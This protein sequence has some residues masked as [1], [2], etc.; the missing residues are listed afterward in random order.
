MPDH[1][2]V[3]FTIITI[4]LNSAGTIERTI[5]SVL[6]QKYDNYEYIVIDGG[7]TDATLS[8]VNKYSDGI[9][10]IVSEVDHGIANAFN[11]GVAISSGEYILFLNSDDALNNSLILNKIDQIARQ[12]NYPD[13][14]Y[15]KYRILQR[16][17][18][19]VLGQYSTR[20]RRIKVSHGQMLSH[21]T[22]FCNK[23]YFKKY[24][25][26]DESYKIAMDF[27]WFLRGF[28]K[29]TSV[30]VDFIVTDIYSGGIST[31][32]RAST[33]KEIIRA[34]VSHDYYKSIFGK[35][36]IHLYYDFRLL[37]SFIKCSFK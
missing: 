21:P 20:L 5:Q 22:L 13:W 11:K 17:T 27:E 9:S 4:S 3:K 10:K 2:S 36:Y 16:M 19:I 12:S 26:F 15:G 24:G 37:L 29:A 6:T 33:V 14:V 30:E 25:L 28:G 34:L 7:S 23:R 18:P 8:V 31:R 32:S 35:I 1:K